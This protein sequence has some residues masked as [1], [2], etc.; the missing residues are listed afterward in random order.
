M[1]PDTNRKDVPSSAQD[2]V[3][4]PSEFSSDGAKEVSGVDFNKYTDR[5]ITVAE[6]VDNMANMGFQATAV[7]DA[8]KLINEMVN[9]STV[10]NSRKPLLNGAISHSPSANS[11]P[12][13]VARHGVWRST[14]HFPRLH[15]KF[16]LI[17]SA[18]HTSL[19]GTAQTC[20]GNC[21]YSWRR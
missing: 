7:G 19:S 9:N 15:V 18:R 11:L 8:V 10:Q 5:N 2:A 14:H 4:K 1:N 16:D 13:D 6:L 12:E 3:L 17:W 20:F 21:D